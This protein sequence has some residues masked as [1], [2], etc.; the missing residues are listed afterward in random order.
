[1]R[2][3]NIKRTDPLDWQK[4]SSADSSV[5]GGG[6]KPQSISSSKPKRPDDRI[7][8]TTDVA[9]DLVKIHLKADNVDSTKSLCNG[10]FMGVHDESYKNKRKPL[11][12]Y[13]IFINYFFYLKKPI[14]GV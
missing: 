12:V 1:M 13:R 2:R 10:D 3:L 8:A 5:S 9:Q 4:S 11:T 14:D 7:E 6:L